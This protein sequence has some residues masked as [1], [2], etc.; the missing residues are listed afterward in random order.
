MDQNVA[1][2]KTLGG[3]AQTDENN[4]RVRNTR[5]LLI[6]SQPRLLIHKD[7]ISS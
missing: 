7:A 2:R 3:V 4:N 5:G 1:P 6:F